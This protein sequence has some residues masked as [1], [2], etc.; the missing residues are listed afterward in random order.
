MLSLTSGISHLVVSIILAFVNK[1]LF[2]TGT[3]CGRRLQVYKLSYCLTTGISSNTNLFSDIS[4]CCTC[5]SC[6]A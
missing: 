3:R 2:F 1:S 6:L 5:R 4:K